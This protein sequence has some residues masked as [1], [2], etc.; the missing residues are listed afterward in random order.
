MDKLIRIGMDTSKSV[1]QVHGVNGAEQVKLRKRLRRGEVVPFFSKLAPTVIAIEACGG[2]HYWA[3]TLGG[4][5]HEVRLIAP[6]HAKP[7]VRRNKNDAA[8]AEALCE[9]MSRPRMLFVAAKSAEEQAA[10]MLAR[11][12]RRLIKTRTQLSNAIRGHAAEFG[13]FVPKGL[14]KVRPLLMQ[15]AAD[16]SL[17]E[18][19]RHLFALQGQEYSHL[20]AELREIE[21]KLKAWHRDSKESRRVAAVPG[22]GPVGGTRIAMKK[23]DALACR[24][25]RHYA[26]WI[27][28]TAKDHS[29]AGK[30]RLGGITRAGD[31]ELRALLVAGAMAVIR[32]AEQHP[33]N[34]SP[35]LLE[36]LKRKPKKLVAVALANKN[37]RIAWKL[38]TSRQ[39][40]DPH[41]AAAVIAKAA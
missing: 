26:A 4:L 35:W 21:A 39:S 23:A 18:L 36:L 22:I 38:L 2:S 37:A 28:L 16:T 41:Y 8:D 31:P 34:A 17:P 15:V 1:F 20:E 24:S 14:S 6:Q 19:A 3:R 33:Q 10:L 25:A 29:T 27:G 30:Q 12:R 9:A 5:G 7:Y 11:V 40:Y 13:L 32:Q